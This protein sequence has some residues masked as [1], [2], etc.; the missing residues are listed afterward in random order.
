[1]SKLDYLSEEMVEETL[2]E[3]AD[4]FFGK[5]KQVDQELE[6]LNQQ[7]EE[8]RKKGELIKENASRL[9]YLLPDE[10]SI[11]FFWT[12]LGLKDSVYPSIQGECTERMSVPWAMTL[13]GKYQKVLLSMYDDLKT[14]VKDYLHGRYVDHPEIKGK[15]VITPNLSN[16]KKRAE[17]INKN[18]E[19][20]NRW[21]KPDDVLAFSRRMNIDESSKR[22]SIGSGLEYDFDHD[23]CLS[24]FDFSS[25]ELTEYPELPGGKKDYY[26]IADITMS[27]FKEKKEQVRTILDNII[28]NKS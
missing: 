6:F 21:N 14:L 1:M 2:K 13:K 20:I 16:L 26:K 4:T 10:D 24:P 5:R 8:L 9:N 23:L 28:K 19:Q 3:A 25:L 12:Q 17:Y 15:K 27:I 7:A 22:E 18:I 11:N